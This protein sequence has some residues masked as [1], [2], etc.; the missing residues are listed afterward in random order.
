MDRQIVTHPCP[1]CDGVVAYPRTPKMWQNV[2]STLRLS[3]SVLAHQAPSG[4]VLRVAACDNH[5][6]PYAEIRLEP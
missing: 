4:S 3:A 5:E 2:G 1:Q 6:C